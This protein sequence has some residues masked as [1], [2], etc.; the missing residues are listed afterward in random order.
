MLLRDYTKSP[1]PV[2]RSIFLNQSCPAKG[3]L[4]NGSTR[5]NSGVIFFSLTKESYH[6]L[7][8]LN[9]ELY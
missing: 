8:K 7:N 2:R 3:A 1:R 5:G 6:V 4:R 9:L